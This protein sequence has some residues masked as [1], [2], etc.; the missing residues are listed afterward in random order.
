MNEEHIAHLRQYLAIH[1]EIRQ[2]HKLVV[3]EWHYDGMEDFVLKEG[4]IFWEI[5]P[6]Q[7]ELHGHKKQRYRPRVPKQCFDNAYKSAVA[8]RGHLRY[9]EGFAF[10]GILPVHHAW[11]IDADDRIVDTTWCGDGSGMWPE[12][13]SAYMGVEFP[14]TYVR[15]LRTKDNIC[16]IDQWQNNWPVLR[17]PYNDLLQEVAA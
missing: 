8:S 12:V 7:P 15:S 3:S 5:S 6:H 14:I 13:G 2:R 4:R 9:V 1:V 17:T 16:V 10:N 11:T